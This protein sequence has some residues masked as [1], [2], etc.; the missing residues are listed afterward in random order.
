MDKLI[1]RVKNILVSPKTEWEKIKLE[2]T[3]SLDVIKDY[4]GILVAV[5]TVAAF[6]GSL[7]LG[8]NFFAAL[9]TAIVSY[10]FMLLG[11]YIFAFV[12]NYLAPSFG[13]IKDEQAAFKL[14]AYSATAALVAGVLN[15]IPILSPLVFLASLYGIYLFYVGAPVIM[16]IPQEKSIVYTVVS[17]VAIIVISFVLAVLTLPF[18]CH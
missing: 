8:R 14:V 15:I 2:P 17:F 18:R 3:N 9:I 11:F 12:I 10:L 1:E 16:H 7:F 13:G 5:P 6:I 4:L